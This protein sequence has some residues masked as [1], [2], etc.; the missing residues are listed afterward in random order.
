MSKYVWKVFNGQTLVLCQGYL[1]ESVYVVDVYVCVLISYKNATPRG[2]WKFCHWKYLKSC[3]T[4]DLYREYV[5]WFKSNGYK[6]YWAHAVLSFYIKLKT[7]KSTFIKGI[8]F[9]RSICMH[10]MDYRWYNYKMKSKRFSILKWFFS[11][12]FWWPP[13]SHFHYF[14]FWYACPTAS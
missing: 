10:K 9:K 4:S 7:A 8:V 13:W 11:C 1:F 5:M 3:V 6:Y 12:I 2:W 14:P